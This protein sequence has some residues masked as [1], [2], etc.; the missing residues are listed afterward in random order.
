M[1]IVLKFSENKDL[2]IWPKN[3]FLMSVVNLKLPQIADL[4][5]HNLVN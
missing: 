4:L 1:L 3:G 2:K 5:Q